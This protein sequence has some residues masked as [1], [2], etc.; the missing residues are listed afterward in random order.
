MPARDAL[1]W[2]VIMKDALAP[3]GLLGAMLDGFE[4]SQRG[5]G[6]ESGEESPVHAVPNP[7]GMFAPSVPYD[8]SGDRLRKY[9]ARNIDLSL[10]YY[11]DPKMNI[12]ITAAAE[13]LPVDTGG[14]HDRPHPRLAD[15]GGSPGRPRGKRST[16]STWAM[17]PGPA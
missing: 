11:V 10:P 13:S 8:T 1:H 17:P 2:Q 4:R 16:P 6:M 7:V 5:M 15:P 12:L 9:F 14:E 3:G